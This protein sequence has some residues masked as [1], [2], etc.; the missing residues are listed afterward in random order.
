M[1]R[2]ARSRGR[3]SILDS[4]VTGVN[5]LPFFLRFRHSLS[6]QKFIGLRINVTA[7]IKALVGLKTS[8][9]AACLAAVDAVG[10]N[11]IAPLYKLLLNQQHVRSLRAYGIGTDG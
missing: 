6:G 10:G 4:P 8:D 2:S 9:G 1:Y 3:G 7:D 11:F 5:C